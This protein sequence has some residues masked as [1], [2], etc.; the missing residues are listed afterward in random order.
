MLDIFKKIF[1]SRNDRELK[2]MAKIVAQVNSLESKYKSMTD[3]ELRG[4]TKEFKSLLVSGTSLNQILPDAFAVAREAGLR[5]LSMRHFDVQIL[6]G[7]TLH[8]GE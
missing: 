2:R 3:D 1:G 4:K 6:G 7:I 8:E 5:T